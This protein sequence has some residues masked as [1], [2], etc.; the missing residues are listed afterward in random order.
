V[1]TLKTLILISIFQLL[2]A[3]LVH[4]YCNFEIVGMGTSPAELQSKVTEVESPDFGLEPSEVKVATAS[5]CSD[6]EYKDLDLVYEYIE[7]KL[8]RIQLNDYY[9]T[10]THLENLKYHY[11]EPSEFY[12]MAYGISYYY[13]NLSFREVFFNSETTPDGEILISSI[14]ITSNEYANMKSKYGANNE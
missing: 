14:A 1:K 3:N 4:A 2:T 11:G 9:P 8:H 13:W 7:K 6:P 10:A 12:E 5:I